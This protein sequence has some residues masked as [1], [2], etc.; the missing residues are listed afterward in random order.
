MKMHQSSLTNMDGIDIAEDY[1]GAPIPL[2]LAGKHFRD[3]DTLAAA[4]T[5]CKIIQQ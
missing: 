3:E 4:E 5:V 1:T 2:Q